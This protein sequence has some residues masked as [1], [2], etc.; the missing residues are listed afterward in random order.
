M[1]YQPIIFTNIGTMLNQRSNVMHCE[2]SCQ[3][4]IKNDNGGVVFLPVEKGAQII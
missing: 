4:Q 3:D 1:A 2:M